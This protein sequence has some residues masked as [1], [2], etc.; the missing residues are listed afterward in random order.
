M[1]IKKEKYYNL[2]WKYLLVLPVLLEAVPA[3]YRLAFR[4]LERDFGFFSA[5]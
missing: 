2:L 3:I 1:R 4:R 5:I